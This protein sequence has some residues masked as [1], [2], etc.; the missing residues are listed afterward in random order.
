MVFCVCQ[1]APVLCP[2]SRE[3]VSLNF[4]FVINFFF[5]LRAEKGPPAWWSN[6]QKRISGRAAAFYPVA[7]CIYVR[8][9]WNQKMGEGSAEW[10]AVRKRACTGSRIL[11]CYTISGFGA[12]TTARKWGRCHPEY[13]PPASQHIRFRATS[14]PRVLPSAIDARS[15]ARVLTRWSPPPV[16]RAAAVC[17]RNEL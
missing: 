2:V 1:C 9:E 8:K 5:T 4:F 12:G 6:V 3:R 13:T 14:Y 10:D 11:V 7:L 17:P 16:A 15:C